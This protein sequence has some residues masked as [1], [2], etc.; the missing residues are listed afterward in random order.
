LKNRSNRED[1]Q[2]NSGLKWLYTILGGVF[3]VLITGWL[4]TTS[5]EVK[6][7]STNVAVL[8]TQFAQVKCDM[9]EIKDIVREIRGDQVRRERRENG[10]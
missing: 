8:Q 9:Q 10:R 2:M 4:L 7:T 1:S 3:V 5:A 6:T